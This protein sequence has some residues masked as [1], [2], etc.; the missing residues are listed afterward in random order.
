M[1]R[2]GRRDTKPELGS[3]PPIC[4]GDVTDRQAEGDRAEVSNHKQPADAA[5]V[6]EK[7]E[8]IPRRSGATGHGFDGLGIVTLVTALPAPQP[9]EIFHYDDVLA[10]VA[11]EYDTRFSAI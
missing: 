9:G 10:R 7:L 4:E 6:I 1:A 3:L 11:S 8:E 5:T 2:T